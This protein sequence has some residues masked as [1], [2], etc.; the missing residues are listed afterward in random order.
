M[1]VNEELCK[2]VMDYEVCFSEYYFKQVF[3]LKP[4]RIRPL[5]RRTSKAYDAI[6]NLFLPLVGIWAFLSTK[7]E[8][9]NQW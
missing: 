2:H 1:R 6:N 5:N 4:D 7:V 9:K 8:I 3:V